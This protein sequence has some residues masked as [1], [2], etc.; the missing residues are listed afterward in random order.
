MEFLASPIAENYGH[1]GFL[2][3]THHLQEELH[4][5]R[6]LLGPGRNE[7]ALQVA[8]SDQETGF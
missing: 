2:S 6:M 3:K 5:N 1:L 7:A 8:L 4:A